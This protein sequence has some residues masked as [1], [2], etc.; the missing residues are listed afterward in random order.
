MQLPVTPCFT[1][2]EDM[3]PFSWFQNWELYL[4]QQLHLLNTSCSTSPAESWTCPQLF[5]AHNSE[6]LAGPREGKW[7][8]QGHKDRKW[9]E[10]DSNPGSLRKICALNAVFAALHADGITS[11][12]VC[13][14]RPER[15]GTSSGMVTTVSSASPSARTSPEEKFGK[16]LMTVWKEGILLKTDLFPDLLSQTVPLQDSETLRDDSYPTGLLIGRTYS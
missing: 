10:Q 12:F 15:E 4:W 1:N 3:L 16:C 11:Y 9:Q 13:W 6:T 7:F 2:F 14:V 8:D 5:N